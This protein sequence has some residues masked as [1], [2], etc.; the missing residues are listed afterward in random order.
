MTL[1]RSTLVKI[2]LGLVLGIAVGLVYGWLIQPV[3]YVD[4]TPESLRSDF[5]VDYVLMV[6]ESYPSQGDMDWVREHLA[7]LGP[8]AAVDLVGWAEDYARGHEYGAVDIRRIS[9]LESALGA[10]GGNPQIEGP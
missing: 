7:L 1:S 9:Q 10:Q 4:T 6:A 3:E 5:Q 2:A 8:T